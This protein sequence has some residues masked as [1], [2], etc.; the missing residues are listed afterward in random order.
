MA[1]G[2]YETNRVYIP[3]NVPK[4]F[5]DSHSISNY[6]WTFNRTQKEKGNVKPR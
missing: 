4:G 3:A 5:L 1:K 2:L 6:N